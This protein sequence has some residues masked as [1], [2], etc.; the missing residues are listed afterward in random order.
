MQR[1]S[2]GRRLQHA[3]TGSPN[4]R[5]PGLHSPLGGTASPS[6]LL[7]RRLAFPTLALLALLTASLLFLLPG[8]SLWAQD[9]E[10]IEYPEDRRDAVATYD[11]DGP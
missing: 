4:R 8:G 6:L 2:L 10:T 11:G 9:A 3:L 5:F 1:T 7:N